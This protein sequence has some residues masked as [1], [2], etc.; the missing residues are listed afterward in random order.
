MGSGNKGH[1]NIGSRIECG[2]QK[3]VGE[4]SPCL[5]SRADIIA[6]GGGRA[7]LQ[8]LFCW[9]GCQALIKKPE[10]SERWN[11][12]Q[13]KGIRKRVKLGLSYASTGENWLDQSMA[14]K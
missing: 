7:Y 8:R 2:K 9:P 12:W 1:G 5:D 14:S 6:C 3:C 4:C 10:T 11:E 13:R